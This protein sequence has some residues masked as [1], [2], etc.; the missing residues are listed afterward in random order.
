M[1]ESS[2]HG[3]QS[4]L[5]DHGLSQASLDL[6]VK[7]QV[8]P[9]HFLPLPASHQLVGQVV[10]VVNN[11]GVGAFLMVKTTC[12]RT[13]KI[14]RGVVFA[15]GWW[16]GKADLSLLMSSNGETSNQ[17]K[18][19]LNRSYFFS[20]QVLLELE[21]RFSA[22]V[23][24][25]VSLAWLGGSGD[26]PTYKG[27]DSK[28]FI[29]EITDSHLKLWLAGKNLEMAQFKSIVEGGSLNS[30]KSQGESEVVDQET[31]AQANILKKMKE[32]FGS[33]K[34]LTALMSMMQAP[35]A[36]PPP[37]SPPKMS[38]SHHGYYSS[39][40]IT[41]TYSSSPQ[42]PSSQTKPQGYLPTRAN[43]IQDTSPASQLGL[44]TFQPSQLPAP[45]LGHHTPA[46]AFQP[47]AV[48]QFPPIAPPAV[49][50]SA[51]SSHQYQ[52]NQ[53]YPTPQHPA[54]YN[55]HAYGK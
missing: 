14:D 32:K 53:P 30:I 7:G 44:P 23:R 16:L 1:N 8:Q 6:V 11:G 42:P 46:S 15:F 26:R 18:I 35:P 24:D 52:S 2:T 9:R 28:P 3:I 50:S 43:F 19:F 4:W 34:T 45:P 25:S 39:G 55:M 40:A 22:G 31:L 33:E 17:Y 48:F 51:A 47:P 38:A 5:I 12:G 21:P 54:Y 36:P 49:P 41:A 10:E 13:F 37:T 29:S 27:L 20:E